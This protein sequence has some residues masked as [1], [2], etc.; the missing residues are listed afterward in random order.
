MAFKYNPFTKSLDEVSAAGERGPTGLTGSTG[1]T[2]ATGPAGAAGAKGDKGDKGDT[3]ETGATGA[4]ET[5]KTIILPAA[6]AALGTTTPATRETRELTTNKQVVDVLKFPHASVGIAWWAFLL[7]DSYDGGVINA[8]ITYMN[9]DTEGTTTFLFSL[10]AGC[11]TDGDPLDLT[12]GT[13]QELVTVVGDTA[14]DLKIGSWTT[15]VTPSGT[16][17][18]GKL[19][20][21]KL[22]RDPTDTEHDTTALDAYVLGLRLE[23]TWTA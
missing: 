7:P 2:G 3:G 15:G 14:E 17:A 6:A 19:L 16:P 1:A 22:Q 4:S 23:Y 8:K 10:F 18:G 12:M 11:A 20:F 21:V 5:V 9:V 13:V